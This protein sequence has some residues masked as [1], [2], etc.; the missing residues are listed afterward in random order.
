M[1][2]L[3]LKFALRSLWKN[4]LYAGLNIVGLAIGLAVSIIIYLY[5]QDEL[6]YDTNVPEYRNI[7]RIESEFDLNNKREQFAGTSL[8]LGPMLSKEFPYINNYTRLH[9][10]EVNVLFKHSDKRFYEENIAVADSNFFDVFRI[11]FMEGDREDCLSEPYSMVVTQSFSKRYFGNEN[12]I[13]EVVSTNNHDYLVTGLIEDWPANTHHKFDAVLSAFYDTV[14][15][16]S[17]IQTL[18]N[19]ESYT[20]L[21]LDGSVE[22]A[23][24]EEDFSAFYDKYMKEVG[25]NFGGFYDVTLTRLDKIHFGR[26]LQYDRSGGDMAYLYSFGAIGLLILILACINYINMATARGLERVREVGMR[27]I[28]GSSALEIRLMIFFEALVLSFL[29]LFIAFVLVE[30]VFELTPFNA[31][32]NKDLALDFGRFPALWWMPVLLCV[33]V[34]LL[35]GLY[36]A[37]NLSKVPEM[38][39]IR[40][41]YKSA[42]HSIW[43]RKALVG[44]Q[45]CISVAVVITALLMYRQME[46][47]RTKDLGFN[48]EDVILVP[49]LSQDTTTENKIPMLHT[50]LRK[51]KEVIATSNATR[52][53]G[54]DLERTLMT[55]QDEDDAA[56]SKVVVDMMRV[57]LDYMPT[58]EIEMLEGRDFVKADKGAEKAKVLVNEKLME[59]MNWKTSIGKTLK[60]GYDKEGVELYEMEV[61]GMVENFNSHSLHDAIEPTVIFLQDEDYGVMHIRVDSRDLV[62]AVNKIERIWSEMDPKNPFQFSFLNKD[63][64]KLYENEHRQSRLIL[65]LTY[66]AIFISFMGLTGLASFTTN[67]RTREIGIRKVLG[68]DVYQMVNLIFR[69]MLA[70]VVLS[71]LLAIPLA[72]ILISRWLDGFAYYA[73]LDPLIFGLSAL[74][75]VLLAYLIV[76][77]HSIK[78]ARGNPVEVLKYE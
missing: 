24:V 37:I 68:A 1:R 62:A 14:A 64:M 70:L 17:Q 51:L 67:L 48:K 75:A 19:V 11:P 22:A 52:A 72:Y 56:F 35:S 27:K 71:V 44:F 36:P 50:K 30:V 15:E 41:G 42:P 73:R 40:G 60:W 26:N 55:I 32:L 4:K 77:Y 29:S 74:F 58:M 7:Y 28:L 54:D 53:P 43:M 45:F 59:V 38:A 9:H 12:P 63:L 10:I 76:T 8:S 49:I 20:F 46:Y 57:G 6:R 31:I 69:E 39:A 13:G 33:G 65:Y 78:V 66:L 3:R 18:W 2:S 34:G 5:L 16:E 47:V 23:H 61:V 21:E 25:E